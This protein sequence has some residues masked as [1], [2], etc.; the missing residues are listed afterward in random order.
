MRASVGIS[1]ASVS[2]HYRTPA[3]V[4]RA[5]DGISV[6]IA[7]GSSVA[8][9]GRSGCGKSTLLGLI[10]GLETPTA[11]RVVVGGR[12]MSGLPEAERTRLRRDELGFVFQ[13][14]NLLPFLTAAEN[15]G[16]Q[17][18]LHDRDSSYEAALELLAELELGDCLHKLPDQLSGGQRQRVAVAGAL[19]HE[20]RV[21]LADEPTGSLDVD[22]SASLVELLLTASGGRAPRWS[23]SPTTPR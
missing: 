16:L 15:L 7:A 3:G 19:M 13:T 17:L 20:P 5:L 23:W 9:M 6:E 10:G 21:L 22:A 8:I 1:L 18:A 2:M 11:G 14:D 12:E 4:V